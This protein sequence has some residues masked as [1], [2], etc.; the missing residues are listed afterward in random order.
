MHSIAK[1]L[2]G[3]FHILELISIFYLM[4]AQANQ[5]LG[6]SWDSG[7]PNRGSGLKTGKLLREL[8]N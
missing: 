7:L 3:H 2:H 6:L 4:R 1:N 8:G 5:V